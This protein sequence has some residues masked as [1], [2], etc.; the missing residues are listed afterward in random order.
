MGIIVAY[1]FL[2]LLLLALSTGWYKPKKWHELTEKHVTVLRFGCLF[3]FV[4]IVTNIV[5]KLL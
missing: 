1:S 3:G 2:A 5:G 4:V